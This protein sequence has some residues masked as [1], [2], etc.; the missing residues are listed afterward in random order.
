M[1]KADGNQ[2]SC[3]AIMLLLVKGRRRFRG[4]NPTLKPRNLVESRTTYFQLQKSA[5]SKNSLPPLEEDVEN[6]KP[7]SQYETGGR[8][9]NI[10]CML[11]LL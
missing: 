8:Q 5:E 11:R 1:R 9:Q 7:E 10:Q 4:V 2:F 6:A 3:M